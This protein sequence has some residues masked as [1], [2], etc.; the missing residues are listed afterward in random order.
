MRVED[1]DKK[2]MSV[3][4]IY[5]KTMKFAW[6]KLA[7]GGIVFVLSCIILGICVGIGLLTKSLLGVYLLF[8]VGV[9][10]CLGV[11]GLVNNYFGY[12]VKAG[13]VAIIA[14]AVT[15]GEVPENQVEVATQMVKERFATSNVYFVVDKLVSGAVSQIQNGLTKVDN[16]FSGVPGLSTVISFAKIFVGIAL[17]Y[18]DECCLGYTFYNKE[19]GAFKSATDGVVIYFQNWKSLMKSAALTSLAVL[20]ITAVLSILPL[21]VFCGIFALLKWNMFVAVIL[22]FV[23]AA[24]FKTAFIDSFMLVKTMVVYM[25][26][27][28]TTE[29]TFDLYGKLCKLSSKFKSLFGKAQEEGSIVAEA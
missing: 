20:G 3:K 6:M 9:C 1:M 27:A 29:I 26:V 18:V 8:I 17:G 7:L 11:H 4:D 25:R 22:A 12:M 10:G 14:T 13:H 28:P 16:I 23:V 2:E 19:E 15:T 21:I 5:L 24:V